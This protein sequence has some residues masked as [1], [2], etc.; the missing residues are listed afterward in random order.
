MAD[1]SFMSGANLEASPADL[2][3]RAT[4]PEYIAVQAAIAHSEANKHIAFA[5]PNALPINQSAAECLKSAGMAI[6]LLP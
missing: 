3:P 4:L 2:S 6:C 1:S 5:L